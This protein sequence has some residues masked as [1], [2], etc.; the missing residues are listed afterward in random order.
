MTTVETPVELPD[1]Y[2]GD[3]CAQRGANAADKG[4]TFA[5]HFLTN[6]LMSKFAG[7]GNLR[8]FDLPLPYLVAAHV[9]YGKESPEEKI[10]YRSPLLSFARTLDDAWGFADRSGR[11]K[12]DV[13][14]LWDATHFVW[15]LSG[16][17]A[18]Q[19]STGHFRFTYAAS[20]K[21]VEVFRQQLEAQLAAGRL[22]N[23]EKTIAVSIVHGHLDADKDQHTADL[24]DAA[25]YLTANAN[26]VE[27][28]G[29]LQ[30]ALANATRDAEWLLYP[31][32][33]MEDGRG[34]S[35]QFP[36]NEYLSVPLFARNVRAPPPGPVAVRVG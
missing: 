20:T 36:P 6:G 26:E 5:D 7:G 28:K 15:K 10:S 33:P 12:F 27:D 24:V 1:L 22:D 9:G 35:A 32:D 14:P 16:I 34:F 17:R 31:R 29:L 21:R 25:A 18:Q 8:W 3:T 4:R 13:V 19:I 30:R 11:K 2:R 23:F